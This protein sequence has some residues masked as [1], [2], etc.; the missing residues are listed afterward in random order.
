KAFAG[1]TGSNAIGDYAWYDLNSGGMTQAVGTKTANELGL[2]DMS[3]NVREWCWDVDSSSYPSGT[4]TDYRRTS[5][6]SAPL[7]LGGSWVFPASFCT[8]A[9][10][11]YYIESNQ[12]YQIGFRV[13][14]P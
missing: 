4:L 8:V 7:I 10:L 2:Y 11:D 12:S 9:F 13:M 6:G 14:R 5:S 1:S 3:G